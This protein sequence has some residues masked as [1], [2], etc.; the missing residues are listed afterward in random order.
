M[1]RSGVLVLG[2]I[3]SA[4]DAAEFE[5]CWI[6]ANGYTMDG[7]MTV[8]DAALS[9][10]LVRGADVTAFRI[11]G[12]LDG[13]VIGSWD[14]RDLTPDTTWNLSF[15]PKAMVFPTG[16]FH[17]GPE[18]QAWNANGSVDDCG[19]P[20]FG[21]NSGTNAQDVCW[22][23]R[24]MTDSMVERFKPFPV[25]PAGAARIECGGPALIG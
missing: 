18:G 20:G 4:A 16:G 6:G 19:T 21:F 23:D 24:W 15:D 11:T 14:L 1:I 5:F 10:P 13:A 22:N 9:K 25:F 12:Y 2:L 7:S 3:A 8:P 17:M